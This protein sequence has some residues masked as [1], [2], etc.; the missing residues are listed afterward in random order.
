MR[1]CF[2]EDV[3]SQPVQ[4]VSSVYNLDGVTGERHSAANRP[5]KGSLSLLQFPA[6]RDAKLVLD[7]DR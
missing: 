5:A 1:K 7:D 2:G 3:S 4:R 6:L